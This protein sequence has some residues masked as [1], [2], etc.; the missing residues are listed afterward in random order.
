MKIRLRRLL[1]RRESAEVLV[2]RGVL[3]G[4]CWK[5]GKAYIGGLAPSL[6]ET[7]RRVER[8]RVKD[9]LRHWVEE[10]KRRGPP[11]KVDE[12]EGAPKTDVRRMAKRFARGRESR[13]AP[14]WGREAGREKR[15]MPTRAK[16]LGL[17]RFW[18]KLGQG[19]V[20]ATG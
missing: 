5:G 3:P 11:E 13:E 1:G 16:V 4:E 15:E 12:V 10:W 9:L 18:E 7:K 14:K 8:E 6:V 20:G 17:R 19:G 2:E